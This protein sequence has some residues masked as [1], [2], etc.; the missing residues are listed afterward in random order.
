MKTRKLLR[1]LGLVLVSTMPV[2]FATNA[3]AL[4]TNAVRLAI[5]TFGLTPEKRDGDLAD[6]IA[7]RLTAAS[8][9][10]L[11]ERRE[12]N[13]VLKEA[14]LGP[15]GVVRAKD[16]VHFGAML[17]ADQFLLGS[18]VAING[19]N[20][21]FIRLVDARTGMIQA[22]NVFPDTGGS[23]D[24]LAGEIVD[25]VR[26]E[27]KR[28]LQGHRDYLAIGVVQNLGVNDRFSD[29]PAQM[30]GSVAAQLNGKVTVLERDVISFLANEV[31]LDMAGLTEGAGGRGAQMQF[32]FWIVDGFYQSYEVTNA[33][34]ELKLRVERVQGGQRSFV[35]RGKPDEEFFAKICDMIGQ[36]LSQPAETGQ[37]V[38][39][40]RQ[41]EI[42]ALETRGKQLVDYQHNAIAT[43]WAS[44]YLY[45]SVEIRSA[46]TPEKLM[47]ALDEATRV[48]ESILLLDPENN[49]AKMRLAGCLLFESE[50]WGGTKRDNREERAARAKEY[51]REVIATEDPEYANEARV[52]LAISCGG[53]EGVEMLR[54]FAAD[55]PDPKAK[56]RFAYYR[57]DLLQYLEHHLLVEAVMPQLRLLLIDDLNDVRKNS[58]E[59][60]SVSYDGVLFAYRFDQDEREKIINKLL[61]ELLEKFPDLK[62]YILLA[63]AGEQ[64][65]TNSP[66]TA[67]FMDSLRNCEEH[68]EL[69]WH[70]SNYFTHLSSTLEEENDVRDHGG[71]TL[72]QRTFD[73]HQYATVVTEAWA[74]QKAAGKGLAPPLTLIGKT[75]LAESY[76]ALKQW[77]EAL[78]VFNELPD[79]SPQ[80]KNECLSHLGLAPVS[81]E[82]PDTAWHDKSDLNKV[83]IAYQCIERR[84]WSTAVLILESMGHRTVGMNRGGPWGYAFAPVLPAV[85]A[86]E[87]R[88][89]AGK[90]VL[91]DPMRFEIGETPYVG[92]DRD[93]ARMFSFEVEGESLWM[94][95]YSQIK[96]FRGD[97]P[98]SA[99]NPLELHEFERTTQTG[100]TCIC[101]SSN[102]VWA[103]TYDDG[104][105]ELDRRTGA[106]RRL[107]MKDGL[108]LN[109]I[110]GLKLH[111][112]TLWI[113]YRNGNNGA[114]GTLDLESH[115][116]STL[117]PN[118]PPAAGNNSQPWYGQAGLDDGRQAPTLPVTSMTPAET[119]EMWFAVSEKG[120]RRFRS[121]G[122]GWDTI[123]LPAPT[124]ARFVDMA[125][126]VTHGLLLLANRDDLL[127]NEKSTS[128]GLF[129]Y[130]YRQDKCNMLQI[131]EGLPSN[132]LTAVAVDGRIAW[133]GGRGFVAVVDVQERKVL[134]IAYVS[135]S[136]IQGIQLG[137]KHAWIAVSCGS[138][139]SYPDFSGKAW[140]GVYRL[141]RSA[142]EPV[143]NRK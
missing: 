60:V 34:V 61:P 27:S 36:A 135:A 85:V 4:D 117:T 83:E 109:G 48:F 134:R 119:G 29:F 137:Q 68:P 75:R 57:R 124:M 92:F 72:Y 13:A 132:D 123:Q 127:D 73:N 43:I 26:A 3:G 62:P 110:S 33:E 20:R 38:P 30:R 140:T 37:P 52:N 101:V 70:S 97:G 143:G 102:Y 115:K 42:A 78:D 55:A 15:S 66:V 142:I 35:L 25:F 86:D 1:F 51:Y 65:T 125:A 19:T 67:Q 107:T 7:A 104:L 14:G 54:R 122:G 126:D 106:C 63:A 84:Q 8:G 28:P 10:D 99:G 121:S 50:H 89:K 87:C 91:K 44:D 139:D 114:V 71:C 133:V 2:W 103:G 138:G 21:L 88:A 136:R 58:G 6:V 82:L 130:D 69:V 94:A 112:R 18:S 131:Y 118:L 32:G 49:A 81:E 47:S 41:G 5:G 45:K 105:F 23:L 100:N 59:S 56:A 108:L 76:L 77:K 24:A 93:G 64:T 128:G 98:F 116:I 80:V 39:P 74:R 96:M 12:L 22:I 46:R 31:Q 120:L 16:V 113:A 141:D 111:G 17:R 40:T 11:V 79:A 53:L 9:F 90:P 129:I 95:T